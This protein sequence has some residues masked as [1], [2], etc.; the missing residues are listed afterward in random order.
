MHVQT[1]I[2]MGGCVCVCQVRYLF[3]VFGEQQTL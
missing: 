1:Y 2:E 3:Y